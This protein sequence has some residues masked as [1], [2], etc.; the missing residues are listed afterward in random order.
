MI[1]T[2]SV[3]VREIIRMVEDDGWRFHSQIGSHR[4]YV[5][6]TKKGRVTIAGPEPGHA[7]ADA[8][9]HLQTGSDR[10]TEE[11]NMRHV[12][13]AIVIEKAPGSNYSAYVPDLPGCVAAAESLEELKRLMEEG[14]RI[15]IKGMREDG[16]P[17]PEPTTD[18]DYAEVDYAEVA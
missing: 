6:P 18:V 17:V 10:R 4:Q 12:R 5:H 1:H 3:K 7:P 15:H 9:D 14:I 8:R 2:R 11:V 16:I 13:Y